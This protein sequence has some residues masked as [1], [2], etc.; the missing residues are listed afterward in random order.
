VSQMPGAAAPSS[1]GLQLAEYR[2]G[3]GRGNWGRRCY[4]ECYRGHYGR[5]YCTWNCYRPRRWW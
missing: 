3:Y 2:H 1:G 4:R 5:M